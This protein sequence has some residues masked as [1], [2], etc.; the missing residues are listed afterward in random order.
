MKRFGD[1]EPPAFRALKRAEAR[2]PNGTDNLWLHGS[3]LYWNEVLPGSSP[4]PRDGRGDATRGHGAG[5]DGKREPASVVPVAFQP[6]PEKYEP[7][8]D[9]QEVQ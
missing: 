1:S 2:A 5:E 3:P 4:S 6:E 8:Q 7:G 9:V